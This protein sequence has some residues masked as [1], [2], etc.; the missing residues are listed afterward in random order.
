MSVSGVTNLTSSSTPYQVL[1]TDSD[2]FYISGTTDQTIN[3]PDT[4]DTTNVVAL[5]RE[6]KFV[7]E[8]NDSGFYNT[9]TVLTFTGIEVLMIPSIKTCGVI[10][11]EKTGQDSFIRTY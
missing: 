3:L 7:F 11:F 6:F 4:A 5:G 2:V 1:V 9:L 10:C 8:P